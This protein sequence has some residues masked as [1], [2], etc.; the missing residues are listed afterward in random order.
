MSRNSCTLCAV[1]GNDFKIDNS[2][3]NRSL[4][5]TFQPTASE[6][7]LHP[8]RLFPS[9]NETGLVN[10]A[11]ASGIIKY[12][13]DLD[14]DQD[15]IMPLTWNSSYKFKLKPHSL[16]DKYFTHNKG[17]VQIDGLF[18]GKR[19]NKLILFIV[20]AKSDETK[21]LAKHKLVYPILSILSIANNIPPDMTIVP[22]YMRVTE[23]AEILHFSIAECDYPD[24]RINLEGFDKLKVVKSIHLIVPRPS[25]K[26]LEQYS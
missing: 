1:G 6:Q 11:F 12:A 3:G 2:S 7:T 20:E 19:E 23:E 25:S 4:S 10:Y 17:Q 5:E 24:P 8:F 16:L 21:S 15:T 18:V 9:I 13:L 14:S 22:V 26:T